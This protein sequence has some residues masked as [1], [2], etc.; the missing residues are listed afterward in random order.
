MIVYLLNT[1]LH[2]RSLSCVSPPAVCWSAHY[3]YSS[4]LLTLHIAVRTARRIR[5]LFPEWAMFVVA[6][7]AH[8]VSCC[9]NSL[10][11]AACPARAPPT[12]FIRLHGPFVCVAEWLSSCSSCHSPRF[13]HGFDSRPGH[14]VERIGQVTTAVH[15]TY[16]A[17]T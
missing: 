5:C 17:S 16:D 12:N 11:V 10:G 2:N 3:K 7:S 1:P 13:G 6:L 14:E 15:S 4:F 9:R 8:F